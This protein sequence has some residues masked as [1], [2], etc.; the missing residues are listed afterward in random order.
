[1]KQGSI[2]LDQDTKA[3][4]YGFPLRLRDRGRGRSKDFEKIF[5]LYY[6]SL[7]FI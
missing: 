1:M 2:L 4:L 7:K 5:I 3:K 6:T